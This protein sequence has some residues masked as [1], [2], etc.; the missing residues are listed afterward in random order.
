M[1]SCSN[2]S[3]LMSFAIPTK[4]PENAGIHCQNNLEAADSS[5][6]TKMDLENQVEEE[7]ATLQMKK[8]KGKSF[9]PMVESEARR[10]PRI[11]DRN[12]GFKLN[13]CASRNCLA[14][15]ALPPSIPKKILKSVGEDIC[16]LKPGMLTEDNLSGKKKGKQA[17][18]A[19][20]TKNF[21]EKEQETE[22]SDGMEDP[23]VQGHAK[24]VKK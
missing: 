4:C 1:I 20:K 21:G 14:C 23:E 8:Q 16:K 9:S 18:G 10:S 24:K 3:A 6:L 5:P 19:Q 12:L 13:S 15:A 17:V 7:V 11:C 22:K 2:S